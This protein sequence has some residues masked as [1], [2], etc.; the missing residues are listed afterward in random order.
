[1]KSLAT[2]ILLMLALMMNGIMVAH[3]GVPV[4]L[5]EEAGASAMVITPKAPACHDVTADSKSSQEGGG[6]TCC[7]SGQCHC[8]V[9]QMAAVASPLALAVLPSLVP[10]A[11]AVAYRSPVSPLMLRPPIA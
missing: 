11:S 5:S 8:L 9:L 6:V 4:S 7:Q 2:R 3:A 10:V 1:M